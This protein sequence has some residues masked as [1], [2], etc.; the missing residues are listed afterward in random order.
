MQKVIDDA[1]NFGRD[2]LK[3][4]SKPRSLVTKLAMKIRNKIFTLKGRTN[5]FFLRYTAPRSDNLSASEKQVFEVG[6]WVEVRQMREIAETL[7][8]HGKCNGLYF[9]PEMEEYC[10]QRFKIIKKAEKIRLE[11]TGELRKL[12]TPS[13]FLDGVYCN[14]HFQGGCDRLCFHYWR[15]VWL[16]RIE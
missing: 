12:R 4:S 16:K 5:Y 11:S 1:C 15:A 13:Y 7:D 10:G 9:M 3:E 8:E 14:G 2:V 6:D